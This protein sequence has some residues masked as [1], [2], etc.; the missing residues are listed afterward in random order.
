MHARAFGR[1]TLPL[2]LLLTSCFGDRVCFSQAISSPPAP[3]ASAADPE[4]LFPAATTLA[5]PAIQGVYRTARPERYRAF[6]G[7]GLEGHSGLGG[8]GFNAAT[9][10]TRRFSL[11][12][13]ADFFSYST[14]FKDQG[15]R[16]QANLRMRTGH[17]TLDWFPFRNRFRLSPMVVFANNNRIFASYLIPPGSTIELNGQE[18]VSSSSDPLHG[19]G[20]I[21]F[22]K[23]SPGFTVGFGN[24]NRRESHFSTQLD[25]GFYYVGQPSL[26]VDFSGSACYPGLPESIG[27]IPASSAPAFQQDLQAF[28]AR[29]R[30][31]LSYASFFPVFSAGVG[32]SF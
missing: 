11:R 23:A 26:K 27:C 25:A 10:L 9:P 13:G 19:T 1:T 8:I 7:L 20:S 15:A 4:V 29:N 22:R 24:M 2:I 5:T 17:G 18:Y 31:N 6:S 12:A 28:I 30:H 3:Q 16:I 14:T 32:Y 21:D